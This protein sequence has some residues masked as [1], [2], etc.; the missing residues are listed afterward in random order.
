MYLLDTTE[1]RTVSWYGYI[2]TVVET[3]FL[4]HAFVSPYDHI[5]AKYKLWLLCPVVTANTRGSLYTDYWASF[6][7]TPENSGWYNA[8]PYYCKRTIAF[9]QCMRNASHET[10]GLQY[11]LTTSNKMKRKKIRELK[12]SQ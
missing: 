2:V 7:V 6:G 5:I 12:T 10:K 4:T 8:F 11:C 1:C 9:Y 3:R